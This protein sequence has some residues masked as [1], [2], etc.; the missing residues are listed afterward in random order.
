MTGKIA[1]SI[2][3]GFIMF[4]S[5]WQVG[6]SYLASFLITVGVF[7]AFWVGYFAGKPSSKESQRGFDIY[8]QGRSGYFKNQ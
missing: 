5:L 7:G 4:I 2:F 3:L 8:D 6:Q 1:L